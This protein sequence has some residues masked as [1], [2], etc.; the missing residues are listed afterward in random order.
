MESSFFIPMG[1]GFDEWNVHI[2]IGYLEAFCLFFSLFSFSDDG[3][4]RNS[5][6]TPVSFLALPH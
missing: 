5:N 6:S 3:H 2:T 1:F 4:G